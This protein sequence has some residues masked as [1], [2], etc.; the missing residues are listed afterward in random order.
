MWPHPCLSV[1]RVLIIARRR[2]SDD[3]FCVTPSS[4]STRRALNASASPASDRLAGGHPHSPWWSG[5]GERTSGFLSSRAKLTNTATLTCDLRAWPSTAAHAAALLHAARLGQGVSRP[6]TAPSSTESKKDAASGGSPACAGGTEADEPLLYHFQ[7]RGA[8]AKL[9][10]NR[11]RIK[12]MCHEVAAAAALRNQQ[13]QSPS[14]ADA[15]LVDFHENDFCVFN[16]TVV[17]DI[18]TAKHSKYTFSGATHFCNTEDTVAEA[19][20]QMAENDCG[21]LLVMDRCSLDIDGG[22]F[23]LQFIIMHLPTHPLLTQK[24][25]GP[26]HTFPQAGVKPFRRYRSG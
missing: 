10:V 23:L 19:I 12:C 4:L 1:S 3:P 15:A 11:D 17:K 24:V 13:L 26:P 22:P 6:G 21:A 20:R 2:V 5:D 8:D 14:H 16:R 7:V 18:L 9:A 25:K